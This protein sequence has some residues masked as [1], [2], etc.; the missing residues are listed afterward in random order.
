MGRFQ[1]DLKDPTGVVGPQEAVVFN[2][3]EKIVRFRL[4]ISVGGERVETISRT[5]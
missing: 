5:A 4:T 2:A 1:R 3:I